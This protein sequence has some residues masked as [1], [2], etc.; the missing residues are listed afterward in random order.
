MVSADGC[1]PEGQLILDSAVRVLVGDPLLLGGRQRLQ[2]NVWLLAISLA[3]RRTAYF[4]SPRAA[5]RWASAAS[6]ARA[7]GALYSEFDVVRRSPAS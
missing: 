4:S 6:A 3:L 7:S 1:T 2:L 5:S